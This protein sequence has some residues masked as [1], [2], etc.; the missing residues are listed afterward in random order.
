[1][2]FFS[3]SL[4]RRARRSEVKVMS[5]SISAT[6][7]LSLLRVTVAAVLEDSMAKLTWDATWGFDL[8]DLDF[9]LLFE[10]TNTVATSR[11]FSTLR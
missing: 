4:M 10:G 5:R 6:I 2:C 8:K 11:Q 1:M 9:S 3:L 7:F